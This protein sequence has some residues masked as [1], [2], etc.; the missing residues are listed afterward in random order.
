MAPGRR[1]HLAVPRGAHRRAVPARHSAAADRRQPRRQGVHGV[2]A[3]ARSRRARHVPVARPLPVLRLASRSCSCRC[4]SSSAAGATA[5]AS[6]PPSSS[7]STPWSA[8]PSCSSALLAT[9]FLYRNETG[10]AHLRRRAD[11]HRPGASPTST[12]RWLFLAFAMAFAVKVPLFPLHTWL[13]DA[14]T[15]APTAGSVILAGVMLKLGTYGFLRF[16]LYLF[17]EA[18]VYFAPLFITLGVIGIIYG[19]IVR[20]DAEATSNASSPTRRSPT[21]ASSSSARS[22][23]PRESIA[24]R[25]APDG[26]PRHLHRRAVPPRRLDLRATPHPRDL[27]AQAASRRWRPIFAAVFTVVML[28][29]IGLPG[30]NGFVGEF[31]ILIGSFLTAPLVGG[32]GRHRRDPR[33]AVPAVGL[34]AGVPRRGRRGQPP[35]PRPAASRRAW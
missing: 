28:S 4:T 20:H 29:S 35:L 5:T 34:P 17:P 23:S 30:L 12:A 16:G 31:L 14:H 27:R 19:A 3:A 21:S 2:D 33:R 32:G 9:V 13:P 26:Q 8:P 11:R 24:G 10:V 6:T 1:R 18:A 7:S 22:R 15:E 25:R